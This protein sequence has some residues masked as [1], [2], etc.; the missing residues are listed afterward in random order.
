MVEARL[1]ARERWRHGKLSQTRLDCRIV[2]FALATWRAA[3]LPLAQ[4]ERDQ[5][6]PEN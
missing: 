5:L 4:G 2:Y 3:S 6:N 1:V